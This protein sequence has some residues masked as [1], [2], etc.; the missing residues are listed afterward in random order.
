[1]YGNECITHN[2][3]R[4]P[5]VFWVYYLSGNLSCFIVYYV[6]ILVCNV[7]LIQLLTSLKRGNKN[8]KVLILSVILESLHYCHTSFFK[9]TTFFPLG[10]S[11]SFCFLTDVL[12]NNPHQGNDVEILKVI[13]FVRAKWLQPNSN[14]ILLLHKK[15]KKYSLNVFF[16]F[17]VNAKILFDKLQRFYFCRFTNV[18]IVLFQQNMVGL[19]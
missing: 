11:L 12:K 15:W 4:S 7:K 9:G 16:S 8:F 18:I 10:F 5:C 6:V 1:M 13:T 2:F 19:W 3:Q 14:Q 17:S